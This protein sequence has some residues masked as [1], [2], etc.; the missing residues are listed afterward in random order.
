MYRDHQTIAGRPLSL[1]L[2]AKM[3]AQAIDLSDPVRGR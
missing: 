2:V 3:P 1:A